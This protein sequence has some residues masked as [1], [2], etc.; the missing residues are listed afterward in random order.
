MFADGDDV[1]GT[2]LTAQTTS[3]NPIVLAADVISSFLSS[4]FGDYNRDVSDRFKMMKWGDWGNEVRGLKVDPQHDCN[5]VNFTVQNHLHPTP[6]ASGEPGAMACT[7]HD[8]KFPEE[9]PASYALLNRVAVGPTAWMFKWDTDRQLLLSASC[10]PR[11]S[12]WDGMF[13]VQTMDKDA[14]P[15]MAAMGAMGA[16]MPSS[17]FIGG[18][19]CRWGAGVSEAQWFRGRYFSLHHMH[20]LARDLWAGMEFKLP[21]SLSAPPTLT[22][23][24][25]LLLSPSRMLEGSVSS[26]GEVVLAALST[27]TPTVTY[28]VEFNRP[29]KKDAGDMQPPG[30]DAPPP[31]G[32]VTVMFEK[33]FLSSTVKFAADANL[34]VRGSLEV[35][36]SPQIRCAFNG[37]YDPKKAKLQHGINLMMANIM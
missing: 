37:V 28:G 33:R 19:A 27:A 10:D 12:R 36:V 5:G 3:N 21:S 34:V 7:M 17:V 29:G 25:R 11:R 24:G 31:E 9:S 26:S 6:T 4:A 32:A 35:T 23:R 16:M 13:Q 20:A 15:Q 8:L 14:N 22:A 18:L 2:S 30:A 1:G